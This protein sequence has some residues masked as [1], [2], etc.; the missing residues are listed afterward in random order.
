M[1]GAHA[2]DQAKPKRKKYSNRK[3]FIECAKGEFYENCDQ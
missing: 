3:A 1:G 2:F